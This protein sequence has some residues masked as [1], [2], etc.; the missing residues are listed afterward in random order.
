MCS[1]FRIVSFL[2]CSKCSLFNTEGI[3]VTSI[4]LWEVMMIFIIRKRTISNPLWTVFVYLMYWLAIYELKF[5][6]EFLCLKLHYSSSCY[7]Q[8]VLKKLLRAPVHCNFGLHG[9]LC[10]VN[11]TAGHGPMNQAAISSVSACM[12][13]TALP[14][15]LAAALIP[16][17]FIPIHITPVIHLAD[18]HVAA[19]LS[20]SATLHPLHVQIG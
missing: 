4:P 20:S 19:C 16:F 13:S 7:H 9:E 3:S 14:Y 2:S 15:P 18:R 11:H 8:I 12:C 10:L 6:M 5:C 17:F 1:Q